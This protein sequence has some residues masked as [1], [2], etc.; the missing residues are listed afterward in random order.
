MRAAEELLQ[1]VEP[2]L[3]GALQP[4]V[5]GG[6]RD[7]V[8]PA[9]IGEGGDALPGVADKAESFSRGIHLPPRPRAPPGCPSLEKVSAMY[10]DYSVIDL[11][12][13]NLAAG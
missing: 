6:P 4:F 9:E 1:V 3:L 12:G 11:P 2:A 7:P 8:E 13:L 5:P 10:L